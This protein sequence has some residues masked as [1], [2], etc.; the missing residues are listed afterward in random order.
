MTKKENI[1]KIIKHLEKS[2]GRVVYLGIGTFFKRF[3]HQ[4]K[5]W[6]VYDNDMD[7]YSVVTGPH[8]CGGSNKHYFAPLDSDIARLNG[9][10]QT[11]KLVSRKL[12]L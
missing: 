9:H 8:F 2:H 10:Y 5:S 1:E 4:V 3:D 12:S 7:I 6:F 11:S